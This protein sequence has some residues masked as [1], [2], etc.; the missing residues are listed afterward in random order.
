MWSCQVLQLLRFLELR[1][2]ISSVIGLLLK[3]T[4]PGF[5][6]LMGRVK[7]VGHLV[8]PHRYDHSELSLVA[9][10]GGAAPANFAATQSTGDSQTNC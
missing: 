3:R 10:V 8:G 4:N 5:V 6:A 9:R 1:V 7:G 2:K